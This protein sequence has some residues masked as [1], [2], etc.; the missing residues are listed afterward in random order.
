MLHAWCKRGTVMTCAVLTLKCVKRHRHTSLLLHCVIHHIMTEPERTCIIVRSI[1][2]SNTS[3][4]ISCLSQI[5]QEYQRGWLYRTFTLSVTC[6][7]DS[8]KVSY[9]IWSHKTDF[10]IPTLDLSGGAI[11]IPEHLQ[12]SWSIVRIPEAKRGINQNYDVHPTIFDR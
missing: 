4:D 6:H 11:W 5:Y 7:G 10:W 3:D 12:I 9:R 2:D 1:D 8:E